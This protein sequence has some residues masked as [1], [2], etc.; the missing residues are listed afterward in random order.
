MDNFISLI[1]LFALGYSLKHIPAFPKDTATSLNLFV[2][3]VSLPALILYQVPNITISNS[4]LV[5]IVMPWVMLLLSALSVL[6]IS[7]IFKWSKKVTGAL[8]L[9]VPLGNTSFLGI[10]MVTSFF[11]AD[12]VSYAVLYD[13]FGTFL[14]LSV[15]G[16]FVLA[17]YADGSKPSLKYIANKIITF[18]PFIALIIAL[19]TSSFEYHD[20]LISSFKLI[21]ASL[22]PVVM[23]AIGFQFK[24]VLNKKEFIPLGVGLLLKL[25]IAPL[26]ALSLCYVF[27]FSGIIPEVTVFESAMPPMVTAGALA[28]MGGL[29]PE[30]VAAMIGW[31]IILSFITLPLMFKLI[32]FIL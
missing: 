7:R 19:L 6:W 12:K 22:V 15:Y 5:P 8:L 4:I 29:A 16:T 26:V 10:P 32:Q 20:Y 30:L 21:S 25:I 31:G 11:G 3:Y 14:A 24:L 13:Q 18:P 2:I 9:L 23:V 1:I 28:I 17:I 27:G